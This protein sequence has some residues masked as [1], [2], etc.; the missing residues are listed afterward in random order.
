VS[1]GAEVG[2]SVGAD[3]LGRQIRALFAELSHA[4]D[5]VPNPAIGD[6]ATGVGASVATCACDGAP[7]SLRE[8]TLAGAAGRAA[9][10][11]RVR[12]QLRVRG[13]EV[14]EVRYRAYG[15][16]YT[17]ATCEWIARALT[18]LTLAARSPAALIQAIGGAT[19]WADHLGVPP[20]RLGRLLVIEDA[21]RAALTD[22]ERSV[23]RT[24][25]SV[26]QSDNL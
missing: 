11:T 17:L 14:H 15:C 1:G 12:F 19:A 18:G 26:R 8:R 23:E 4:G 9:L 21:L 2:T 24:A 16:P 20:E 6:P 3:A 5:I 13:L 7:D 25:E 10:G 22:G